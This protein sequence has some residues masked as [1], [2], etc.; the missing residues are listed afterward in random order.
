MITELQTFQSYEH[1]RS[2]GVRN[3]EVLLYRVSL[4]GG[5][6]IG[7]ERRIQPPTKD[8]CGG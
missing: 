6:V 2:Q 5:G 8:L 1:P 3:S 4:R 7:D